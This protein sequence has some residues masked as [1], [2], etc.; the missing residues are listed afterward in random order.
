MAITF[1]TATNSTS[2]TVNDSS[3]GALAGDFVTFTNAS[4]GNSSLNTHYS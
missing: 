4:T 2:V 3:H 1:I